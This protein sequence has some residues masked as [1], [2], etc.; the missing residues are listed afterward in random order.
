MTGNL[1]SHMQFVGFRF[2]TELVMY[3]VG[4]RGE[5]AEKPG[6]ANLPIAFNT[7]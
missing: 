6:R 7:S 4:E 5:T 1:I 2:L 3:N